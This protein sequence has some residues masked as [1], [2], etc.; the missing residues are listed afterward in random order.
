MRLGDAAMRLIATFCVLLL[1]YPA[2]ACP[3]EGAWEQYLDAARQAFDHHN[4]FEAR[5]MFSAS[6][7]AAERSKQDLKLA[8]RLEDIAESYAQKRRCK[9]AEAIHRK[10]IQIYQKRLGANH[11]SVVGSI[12]HLARIL[13]SSNREQ[14]ASDWETRAKDILAKRQPEPDNG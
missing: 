3:S 9:V 12:M 13:R 7:E 10:A 6:L 14:E 1:S 4:Y 5:R 2:L 11:L 8:K